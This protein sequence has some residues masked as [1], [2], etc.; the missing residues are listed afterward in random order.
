M[1]IQPGKG[2]KRSS[3]R[4]VQ[5]K[6]PGQ[7]ILIVCEGT[8]TEPSYFNAL[9][10][11]LRLSGMTVDGPPRCGS[12]PISVVDF[13][14]Q[15]KKRAQSEGNRYDQIWC[16]IDRDQHPSFMQAIDKAR[17]NGIELAVSVP[18]FEFWLTLHFE[19]TTRPS[20]SY[21]DIR[22][23][24]EKH[25]PDYHR[26]G[27]DASALIERRNEAVIHARRLIDAR[28]DAAVEFPC[29][30]TYVYLLVESIEALGTAP[31]P[32]R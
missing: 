30:C 11:A 29:P 3:L 24:L 9:R 27:Y 25:I 14:L 31:Q 23:Q 8:K 13:A 17:A 6:K 5:G 26:V 22:P 7:R 4:R 15:G 19:Y 20:S 32:V 21:N 12:A 1:A 28:P 2:R 16:V 18:C 10:R